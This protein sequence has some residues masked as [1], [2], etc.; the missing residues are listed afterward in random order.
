MP[1]G[2]PPKPVELKKRQGTYRVD[3]DQSRGNLVPVPP[4]GSD[5]TQ[6]DPSTALDSVLTAGVHWIASTDAPKVCLLREAMED[7]ARLRNAGASAKDV[8]EARAEVAKLLSELGFDPT[9]R[10]K[11]GLAEVK[12]Q[13]KLEEMKARRDQRTSVVA[14]EVAVDG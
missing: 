14:A 6:F 8:R 13:S 1:A 9:A 4:I 3:R 7:Y 10:A 11:L 12:A 5:V 2:R